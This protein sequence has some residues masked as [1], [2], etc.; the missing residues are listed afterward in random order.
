VIY[1]VRGIFGRP[2]NDSRSQRISIH[3]HVNQSR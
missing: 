3:L 2:V 1:T